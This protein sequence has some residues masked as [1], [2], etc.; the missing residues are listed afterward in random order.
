MP[1][2][3][4]F[5][6]AGERF[7]ENT[8]SC[9]NNRIALLIYRIKENPAISPLAN[10]SEWLPTCRIGAIH[11]INSVGGQA[12][13]HVDDVCEG[14]CVGDRQNYRTIP[15]VENLRGGSCLFPPAPL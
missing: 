7:V 12:A 6:T 2:Q 4:P 9:R 15:T 11:Q 13:H 10:P 1:F 14:G 5:F 8:S 3:P